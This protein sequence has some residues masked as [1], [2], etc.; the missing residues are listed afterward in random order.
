MC[1]AVRVVRSG[2]M[3]SLR[4]SKYFSVPRGTLERYVKD[5]SRSPEELVDVHLGRTVLPSEVENKLVE[6]CITMAQRYY[7]LRRQ[8]IKHMSFQ[9]AIRNGLNHPFNEEKSAAGRKWLWFFLKRH[10]I[11]SVR[12]PEGIS[13]ARV[14]GFTSENVA[15]FF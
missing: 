1:R 5:T 14:K 3:G 2:E 11:L 12:T 7:G 4:A 15:S 10:P 13:A 9:L 6:Y 8:D